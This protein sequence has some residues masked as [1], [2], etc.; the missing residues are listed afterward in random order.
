MNIKNGDVSKYCTV[1]KR[2]LFAL[3]GIQEYL[4]TELI[5]VVVFFEKEMF[6]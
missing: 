1:K 5:G 3:K 4:E 6:A 2:N